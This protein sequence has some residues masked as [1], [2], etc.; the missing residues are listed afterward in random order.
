MFFFNLCV[1]LCFISK[2][3]KYVFFVLWRGP[4]FYAWVVYP[5]ALICAFFPHVN[6]EVYPNYLLPATQQSS[7]SPRLLLNLVLTVFWCYLHV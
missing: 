7:L 4:I 6:H 3:P 5:S 1:F 2:G